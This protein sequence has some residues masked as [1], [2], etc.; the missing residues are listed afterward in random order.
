MRRSEPSV[1]VEIGAD[2]VQAIHMLAD[3]WEGTERARDLYEQIKP[4][5][6]LM[7]ADLQVSR[8]AVETP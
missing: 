6:R 1:V 5:L 3:D 7:D 4:F 8:P 2:R